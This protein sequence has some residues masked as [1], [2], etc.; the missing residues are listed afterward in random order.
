MVSVQ[1][2][3]LN[4]AGETVKTY[5]RQSKIWVEYYNLEKLLLRLK[6]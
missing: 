4:I 3:K 6:I 2:Y 5:D 1:N